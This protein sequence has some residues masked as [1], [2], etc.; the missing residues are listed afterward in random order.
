MHAARGGA[1][2]TC[3]KACA[4]GKGCVK[5]TD[6]DTKAYFACKSNKCESAKTSPAALTK[7]AFPPPGGGARRYD[8]QNYKG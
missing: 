3:G 2:P 5:D 7:W 8:D 4:K 6:C 1:G